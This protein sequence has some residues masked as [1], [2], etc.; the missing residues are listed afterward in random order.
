MTSLVNLELHPL[1]RKQ[2]KVQ[3]TLRVPCNTQD[4]GQIVHT[5]A[6]DNLSI[7]SNLPLQTLRVSASRF[8]LAGTQHFKD[9]FL[10]FRNK[11]TAPSPYQYFHIFTLKQKDT[12]IWNAWL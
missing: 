4:Y 5:V 3:T 10:S 7:T 12:Y 2:S 1:H 8:L 9:F 6:G 11:R